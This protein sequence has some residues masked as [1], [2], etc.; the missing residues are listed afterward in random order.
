M[1]PNRL[2]TM[3]AISLSVSALPAFAANLPATGEKPNILLIYADDLG[4]GDLGYA[5]QK[6][7]RTPNIDRLAAEGMRFSQFRGCAVCA[8]ARASLLTG[9]TENHAPAPNSGG[10]ETL[11]HL[12]KI[13]REEFDRDVNNPNRR[14]E[15]YFLGQLA[16]DS[17]YATAYFGKLGIGY[18]ETSE[19]I[20]RYG[21]DEH[22]GL[23]DSVICWSFYPEYYWENG[24]KV[25]L[26]GNP[27]FTKREPVSPLVGT[28]TMTYTEDIWLKRCMDYLGQKRDKPFFVVYAT[29]LPHGPASIAEKDHAYADRVE[30]TEKERVFASMVDKLDKS[31]GTLTDKLK[32]LGLDKNTLVI[33]T[34][35][36][37]HESQTYTMLPQEDGKFW[38]GHHA[39][40]DRFNGT[41]GRRGIKRYSF[42]GG[43][44]VPF[45]ARWP[46]RIAAGS[47]ADLP[48]TVYDIM[49]T[50]ADITGATIPVAIDG[51]SFLPTLLGQ[52][53]QKSHPYMFWINTTGASRDCV[54]A[55]GWKLIEEVDTANS[56]RGPENVGAL[57][58]A[59]GE[60]KKPEESR[61]YR[62]AL[63]DLKNDSLEKVDLSEKFPERVET[64]KLLV[65]RAKQPLPTII[66]KE[67]DHRLQVA[68]PGNPLK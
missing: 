5:G 42:E 53:G 67:G 10:M 62:W 52:P 51:I 22:C 50:V 11:L 54:I 40:E 39:G 58:E 43:L 64:M 12:G 63:Y 25:P 21:F 35:D 68:Q 20:A 55:D 31:V 56:V 23:Y 7:I 34:A 18:T 19:G 47:S 6:E 28:N 57:G 41:G 9:R 49:P 38:D 44:N 16:K 46:G 3:L 24:T 26:P 13:T 45:I 66:P 27:K 30:W 2:K 65:K 14:M 32:E 33:F 17:G 61:L 4:Q 60:K 36:N 37:G 1:K 48:A 8:P 29:Q 59:T 15:T